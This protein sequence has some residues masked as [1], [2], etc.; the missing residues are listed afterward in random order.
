MVKLEHGG[1]GKMHAQSEGTSW[2]LLGRG[3]VDSYPHPQHGIDAR[4]RQQDSIRGLARRVS[5]G[6][7]L[8]HVWMHR[9]C[10]EHTTE[11]EEARRQKP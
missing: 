8:P 11:L 7:L 9:A 6:P 5:Y 1:N 2:L 4:P 10:Q 3:H